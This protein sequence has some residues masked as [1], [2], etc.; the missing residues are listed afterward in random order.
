MDVDEAC[1]DR[2][3]ITPLCL[4]VWG[5]NNKL[6]KKEENKKT[7]LCLSGD[8]LKE[9]NRSDSTTTKEKFFLS[10]NH[11]C[12]QIRTRGTEAKITFCVCVWGESDKMCL[13]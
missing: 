4:W 5:I 12:F 6:K 9:N 10:R 8:V 1:T 2:S 13:W 3:K 7:L 11:V